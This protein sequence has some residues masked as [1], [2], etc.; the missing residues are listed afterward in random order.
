MSNNNY[1]SNSDNNINNDLRN[2]NN[3]IFNVN[4]NIQ[5]IED[6]VNKK[7]DQDYQKNKDF[8]MGKIG[9]YNYSEGTNNN[10]NVSNKMEIDETNDFPKGVNNVNQYINNKFPLNF[11]EESFKKDVKDQ[12]QGNS[13]IELSIINE[14]NEKHSDIKKI[15]YLR[16]NTLKRLAKYC[17]DKD[18]SSTLNYLQMMNELAIYNDFLNYSLL[19]IDTIRIPLTMDNAALLLSQ[20]GNLINSKYDNYKKTGINSALV[21]LKIFSDRIITTKCSITVGVD[22]SKEERLRKCD[23]IIDSYRLIKDLGS[24]ISITSKDSLDEVG[25]NFY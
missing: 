18:V 17:L 1:N 5:N 20:V 7:H 9:F 21:L 19:Q 22:L 23:K 12:G 4:K 16:K 10:K 3:M 14:I 11:K 13:N 6:R 8:N 25:N 24:F 2:I 15:L